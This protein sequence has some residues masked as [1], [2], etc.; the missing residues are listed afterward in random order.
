MF[1][2][3]IFKQKGI[4]ILLSLQYDI[5]I[6]SA[7]HNYQFKPKQ[8]YMQLSVLFLQLSTQKFITTY[9][10]MLLSGYMRLLLAFFNSKQ[11][12]ISDSPLVIGNGQQ[13]CIFFQPVCEC[14]QFRYS[15]PTKLLFDFCFTPIDFLKCTKI[16]SEYKLHYSKLLVLFIFQSNS[17]SH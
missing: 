5:I 4:I 16:C 2:S 6:I 9:F 13:Q 11:M 17:F 1:G 7:A 14:S 12:S 8:S 15:F 10:S 3:L